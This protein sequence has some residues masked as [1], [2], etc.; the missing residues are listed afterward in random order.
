MS[1]TRRRPHPMVTITIVLGV[2]FA[3]P[4][5]FLAYYIAVISD[6]PAY[7]GQPSTA[8]QEQIRQTVAALDSGNR[9]RSTLFTRTRPPGS[10]IPYGIPARGSAHTE[11]KWMCGQIR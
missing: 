11:E 1:K 8:Y 2:C 6:P 9:S 10:E 4:T 5:A 3:I 7:S